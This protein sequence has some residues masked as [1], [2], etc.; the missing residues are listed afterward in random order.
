MTTY[1]EYIPTELYHLIIYKIKDV[2]S[3]I[4]VFLIHE[5]TDT[6]NFWY[7]LIKRDYGFIDV[8]II[9]NSFL[10]NNNTHAKLKQYDTT[11]IEYKYERD[12]TKV[13]FAKLEPTMYDT[14]SEYIKD[15]DLDYID[16]VVDEYLPGNVMITL[17]LQNKEKK[18]LN[19]RGSPY[20]EIID[21]HKHDIPD[22]DLFIKKLLYYKHIKKLI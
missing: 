20:I 8:T 22:Y 19:N 1:F 18:I 5:F 7:T 11:L 3:I 6:K 21:L 17:R 16:V 15:I 12:N 14:F 10:N 9:N 13:I 2:E 4:N